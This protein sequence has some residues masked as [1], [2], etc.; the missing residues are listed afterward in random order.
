MPFNNILSTVF[1]VFTTIAIGYTFARLKKIDLDSIIEILLFIAIPCLVLSSLLK[2]ELHL[3]EVGY[4]FLSVTVVITGVGMLTYLYLK[5]TQDLSMKGLLLPTMFMNS[6]NMALPLSLL[7]FGEKGLAIAIIYYVSVSVFVYTLGISIAKGRDGLR[8]VFRLPLIYATITGLFIN[9][10]HISLPVPVVTT[11]DMIG[12]ATIP[13]MLISLGYKLESI[14]I[15]SLKMALS[16]ATIRILG[17]FLIA[18]ML[19]YLFQI[20]GITGKIVILSS[21]MPSAVINFIFSQRYRL[22]PELVASV[23]LV[24]TVMSIFTTPIILGFIIGS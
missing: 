24:S 8:E 16:G 17:G 5:L 9:L 2:N 15:N 21:S 19:V 23:I 20:P 7:A 22:N 18:S 4:I 14:H 3:H 6:G 10:M 12:D 11:I 1:P 13:L